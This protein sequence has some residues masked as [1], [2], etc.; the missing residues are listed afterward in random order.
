M[1]YQMVTKLKPKYNVFGNLLFRGGF[2]LKGTL[3][4]YAT[5]TCN[6]IRVSPF[7]SISMIFAMRVA[8]YEGNVFG[9]L[10]FRGGFYLKG[11]LQKYATLTCNYIRVSPFYSISMIFAMRVAIY[12]GNKTCFLDFIFLSRF[13]KSWPIFLR[14]YQKMVK[15]SKIWEIEK[16][17]QNQKCKFC[18]PHKTHLSCQKSWK[19]IKMVKP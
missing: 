5:L 4:K 6:Y 16:K 8:I 7:Y 9:N 19:L 10:L 17:I 3:Q 13:P 14:M 12:E 18:S 1:Y 2:Y 11:T 15:M